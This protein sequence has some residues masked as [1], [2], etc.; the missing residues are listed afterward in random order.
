MAH[1]R[2]S[3]ALAGHVKR[4]RVVLLLAGSL[5]LAFGHKVAGLA[6]GADAH[7]A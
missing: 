4:Q 7:T 6:A 1:Y 5:F 3:D 2:Q